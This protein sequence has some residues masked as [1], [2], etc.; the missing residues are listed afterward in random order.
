MSL[1]SFDMDDEQPQ[2]RHAEVRR[3]EAL[4]Q[5][6]VARVEAAVGEAD[7]S[8][9]AETDWYVAVLLDGMLRRAI[10][11]EY[12]EWVGHC[13]DLLRDQLTRLGR[14]PELWSAQRRAVR[15]AELV[16][17]VRRVLLEELD[18]DLPD[19][20]WDGLEELSTVAETIDDATLAAR[21]SLRDRYPDYFSPMDPFGDGDEG[22]RLTIT[23]EHAARAFAAVAAFWAPSRGLP[24]RLPRHRI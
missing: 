16:A 12:R 23:E 10:V 20:V 2:T 24:Y 1:I 21:R 15:G 13:E 3:R 8:L 6:A 19:S 18:A 11:V 5:A 14:D 17:L 9:E 22:G 4:L 7:P